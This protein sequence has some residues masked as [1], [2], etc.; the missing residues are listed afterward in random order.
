VCG[1][2]AA[3]EEVEL[4]YNHAELAATAPGAPLRVYAKVRAPA[5]NGNRWIEASVTVVG[6]G[7]GGGDVATSRVLVYG[8]WLLR[9]TMEGRGYVGR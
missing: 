9:N 5:G 3:A 7:G 6:W 8:K 1:P 4:L 2:H